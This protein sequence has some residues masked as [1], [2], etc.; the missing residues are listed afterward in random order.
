MKLVYFGSF[1]LIEHLLHSL[2]VEARRVKTE[3]LWL[4]H[5][6]LQENAYS[7]G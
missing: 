6:L 7:L 4:L 5:A 2:G 3:L 1:L